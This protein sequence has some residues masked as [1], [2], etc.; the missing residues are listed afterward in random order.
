[1]PVGEACRNDVDRA[2]RCYC[3]ASSTPQTRRPDRCGPAAGGSDNRMVAPWRARPGVWGRSFDGH[4]LLASSWQLG[5]GVGALGIAQTP[6][7]GQ[8]IGVVVEIGKGGGV[9]NR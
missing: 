3:S 8:Q 6:K 9:Q 2:V 5:A 4:Y 1:A 7:A